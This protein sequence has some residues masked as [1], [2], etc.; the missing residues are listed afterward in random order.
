MRT[1][2]HAQ[3]RKMGDRRERASWSEASSGIV[4]ALRDGAA[5]NGIAPARRGGAIVRT[6]ALICALAVVLGFALCAVGCEG[7]GLEPPFMRARTDAGAEPPAGGSGGRG[8][9]AGSGS[10]AGGASGKGGSGGS[11]GSVN[12][13]RDGGVP[14]N[15]ADGGSDEDAGS[16]R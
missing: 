2:C 16:S 1:R 8:S 9:A 5:G 14:A 3:P 7:P 11:A 12:V 6:T 4:P 13:D 15:E 10:P